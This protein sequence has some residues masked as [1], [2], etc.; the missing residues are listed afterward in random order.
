VNVA[1]TERLSF[2]A[3]K[4]GYASIQ[5]PVIGKRDGFLDL[6]A[7]LKYVFVRDVERQLLVIGGFM[8]EIPSGEQA[9]FQGRG[10]GVFTAF[11]TVGKEFGCKWH[12]LNTLGYQF[13][14]NT[15]YNS[16]FFYNSFHIDRQLFGFLYPLAELN[17]FHYTAGGYNGLPPKLGEGD[18]LINFGTTGVNGNDLVTGALGLK[19]IITQSLQVGAAYEVPLSN[20]KDLIDNRLTLEVILRY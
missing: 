15:D 6:A 10:P 9:V 17:W 14:L 3:D 2:I 20:R 11:G 12:V 7:G 19:A 13:P 18:G 5:S 16:T 1:L 4:D 8:Y